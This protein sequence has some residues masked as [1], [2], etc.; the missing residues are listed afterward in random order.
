MRLNPMIKWLLAAAMVAT[1]NAGEQEPSAVERLARFEFEETHMASPFHIVLYSNDAAAAR[2]ASRAAFD[3]IAALN[4]VLSDY[5]PE[6]ELSRLSQ[7]AGQGPVRV[8]ADLFD[9]LDRSK[10]MYE[11]SGGAFDVTIAPVGRLWRRARRDRKLPDP[12]L[13]AEAKQLVG[14]DKMVL[15]PAARTVRLLQ[16]GMKLDVGG[17]AKGYAAQAA[18][19]VLK[20]QG[21]RRALVGGAGDIVVG[22]PPPDAEGWKVAIAPVDSRL[23]YRPPTL[24]LKNA[25]VSTAGDAERFVEIDGHRY[26][27]IVN[28][29]TGMGHEDRAAVTVVAPDGATADAMETTAYLLGPERGLKLVDETPGAAALFQRLTPEGVKTFESSRFGQVPKVEGREAAGVSDVSRP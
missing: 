11:R 6:S 12:R 15:D 28:P 8:G 5:D 18:L 20:S 19:D 2:R 27:H 1:L 10:R 23:T 25:A 13:I 9:V 7:K 16:P 29:A 14:S 4:A 3:R 17:I 21:I 24:L 26:S 22:D